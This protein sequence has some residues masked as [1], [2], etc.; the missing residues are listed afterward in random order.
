MSNQERSHVSFPHRLSLAGVAFFLWYFPSAG[1]LDKFLP[2][3]VIVPI[4]MIALFGIIIG[5]EVVSHDM[6]RPYLYHSAKPF[7]AIA[8]LMGPILLLFYGLSHSGKIG[9]GSDRA[10]ALNIGI[11]YYYTECTRITH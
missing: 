8:V 9:P 3:S 6:R 2:H 7:V 10:D 4:C 5:V 1:L 11:N